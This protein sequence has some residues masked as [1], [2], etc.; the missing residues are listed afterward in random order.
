[1]SAFN[2]LKML[3]KDERG[4]VLVVGAATMP[5]LMG[6]AALAI[7]TVQLTLWKRQLQRT[8]DSAAIAGAFAVVQEGD[9]DEQEAAIN[10][11]VNNDLDENVDINR[12]YNERPMLQST[13]VSAGSYGEETI[14]EDSCEDRAI[15]TCYNRAVQVSLTAQR[16]LPFMRLFTNSANTLRAE[17]TAALIDDGQ[18]CMVSLYDETDPG[19]DAGGNAALKLGCGIISNSRAANAV[20]ATGSSTITATPI[21]AVG[22]ISGGTH[23]AAGTQLQPFSTP[24]LDPFADRT[25]PT[26]PTDCESASDAV[27]DVPNAGLDLTDPAIRATFKDVICFTKW[28]VKG[29]LKLPAGT[30]F[31]DNGDLVLHG[32]IQG[33]GVT[34]VLLGDASDMKA[35]AQGQLDI[36]A[37]TSGNLKGIAM[38]RDR[39]AANQ[40]IKFNGG[41]DLDVTGA[42]YMPKSDIWLN[43]GAAVTANCIQVVGRKLSFKGGGEIK[44][45]CEAT[46]PGSPFRIPVVRLVS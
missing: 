39:N 3:R 25:Q 29:T 2:W 15:A 21:A 27:L 44:N 5:L 26:K 6:S 19:F 18:Y 12:A 31:V 37:P 1:M 33:D 13:V 16:S 40:I 4:N 41:A 36:T 38:W 8:A 20:S 43:G 24:A 10:A 45:K 23:F 32:K 22:G 42:I 9:V 28:D 34:I 35:N 7:D 46:D 17:A 14:S 11:A 30:Y